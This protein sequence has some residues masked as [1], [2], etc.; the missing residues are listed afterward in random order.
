MKFLLW[1]ELQQE[2]TSMRNHT[3]YIVAHPVWDDDSSGTH[4]ALLHCLC[5]YIQMCVY[6]DVKTVIHW[7]HL[8]EH[9]FH[10]LHKNGE[11]KEPI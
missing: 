1:Q 5:E 8:N 3:A 7:K 11:K 10:H 4:I 6:A 2:C 9:S